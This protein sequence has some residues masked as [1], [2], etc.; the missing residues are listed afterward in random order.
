[1]KLT[2]KLCLREAIKHRSICLQD[3]SLDVA[4]IESLPPRLYK[5]GRVLSTITQSSGVK[6]YL[7]D[8]AKNEI[9]FCSADEKVT[10]RNRVS[11]KI[12]KIKLV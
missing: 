4:D 11:W 7:V 8:Q 9:Y 6:L 1:M 12:R 2:V 3:F 5:T 10:A